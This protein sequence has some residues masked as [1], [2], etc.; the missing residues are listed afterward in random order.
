MYTKR[1]IIIHVH[2]PQNPGYIYADGGG[3]SRI[4]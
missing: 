3:G 1:E 4:F 2:S